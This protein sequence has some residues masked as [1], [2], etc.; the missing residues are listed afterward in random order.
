HVSRCKT[1][2]GE[3][4]QKSNFADANIDSSGGSI[5]IWGFAASGILQDKENDLRRISKEKKFLNVSQICVLSE[6]NQTEI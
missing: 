1:F 3:D 6:S 2:S 5:M 4:R